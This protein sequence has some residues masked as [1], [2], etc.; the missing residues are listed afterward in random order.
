MASFLSEWGH[1]RERR[2]QRLFFAIETLESSEWGSVIQ[3]SKS[4]LEP[5]WFLIRRSLW[6][7][8]ASQLNDYSIYAPN[9]FS[10]Q[11]E[12]IMIQLNEKKRKYPGKKD[13]VQK[14]LKWL[15]PAD[16]CVFAGTLLVEHQISE[17]IPLTAEGLPDSWVFFQYSGG[18]NEGILIYEKGVLKELRK[19][20]FGSSLDLCI[21]LSDSM[22]QEYRCK[23]KQQRGWDPDGHMDMWGSHWK[24]TDLGYSVKSL[25]TMLTHYLKKTDITRRLLIQ[26]RAAH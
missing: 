13:C 19:R 3:K 9:R 23:Y 6:S 8:M 4:P 24:E 21:P 12:Y 22:L 7:H 16:A 2:R 20:P 25:H 17:F 10:D 14:G 26:F 11:V 5:S 18:T 1:M 15:S